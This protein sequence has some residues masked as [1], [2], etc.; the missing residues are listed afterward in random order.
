MAP[1]RSCKAEAG[2]N[3]L[4]PMSTDS[5][6][7][8]YSHELIAARARDLWEKAGCPADRDLEFW[9]AAETQLREER[10]PVRPPQVERITG[11]RMPS[12]RRR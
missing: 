10:P 2:R 8:F 7:P 12:R 6:N 5:N 9:L 3:A 11:T 4:S 1:N